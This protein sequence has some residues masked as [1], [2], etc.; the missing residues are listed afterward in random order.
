MNMN[1]Q[2]TDEYNEEK[3]EGDWKE[4]EENNET[5]RLM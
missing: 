3:V 5:G 1:L 2:N 4:L